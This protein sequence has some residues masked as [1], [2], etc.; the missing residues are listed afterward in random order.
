M[1][2]LRVNHC[3][4]LLSLLLLSPTASLAQSSTAKPPDASSAPAVTTPPPTF[5]IADVHPSPYT[6][7]AGANSANMRWNPQGTD[8]FLIHH[9]S[10]LE[11]IDFAYKFDSDHVLGG[12][13][14]LGFD[15]Y[16]IVAKQP[17]STPIDTTRLMVR[18]L[19]TDRFKLVVHTDTRPMPAQ[20]LTVGRN[21]PM[22]KPAEN[23]A[24]PSECALQRRP[25]PD[26]SAP[27]SYNFSCRNITMQQFV[28]NI[29]RFG[30]GIPIV[31][32]TSL[33]G[34]WD[35]DIAILPAGTG[36]DFADDLA[37]IGLR[38]TMGK[39]PQPVLVIDSLN[40]TPTPNSPRLEELLPPPPLPAFDVTV[41]KPDPSGDTDMKLSVDP[42][43]E[44]TITHANLQILVGT[45][46][47]MS[48]ANIADVPD[49]VAKDRWDVIGKIPQDAYPKGSNGALIV[50]QDDIHLMIRSLL[51]E[52]FGLKAHMEDRPA[53][54]GWSLTAVH[55]RLKKTAN[56]SARTSCSDGPPPGEKDPRTANP[57]REH[58][59]WCRNMTMSQFASELL[60]YGW[61]YHIKSPVV[62]ETHLNGS[63]D[64]VLNWSSAG[65]VS[66]NV[67]NAASDAVSQV[68]DPSG[69]ISLQDAVSQQ[70]GLKLKTQ[71]QKL[72]RIVI[73][74]I[75]RNPTQN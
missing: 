20:L 9:G 51:V 37:R 50:S 58:A 57:I 18:A 13:T 55:P 63:Y 40:E 16:E 73:D 42:S 61:D 1:I 11:L 45:A 32:Q 69:A 23:N 34:A 71:R 62:D 68:A 66:P 47:N 52:R 21:A 14:S 26:A 28:H 12:P 67:P 75:E 41:I 72:P 17:P 5:E 30:L 53:D 43:G 39:A 35:L 3:I 29:S 27:A 74:H 8:R 70:L 56:A 59:I 44:V 4:A 54:G 15:R 65:S 60:P 10:L 31:D 46:F 33:K 7:T 64:I 25:A 22:M 24:G 38:L 2:S 19:L 48:G 49:F 36:Y 6:Y